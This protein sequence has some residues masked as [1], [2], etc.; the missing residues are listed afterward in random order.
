MS[1]IPN[2]QAETTAFVTTAL[3]ASGATFDSGIL[4][5]AN[6]SQVQTEIVASH[7]GTIDISFCSDA[8]G[9][10]VVRSLSIPYT[11]ADGYQFFAAPAFVNF[12][13]YEFTNAVGATQTDFYYTT[14]F[15]STAL[16]PQLLTTGAFIAPAMVAHLSR[17]I[18]VGKNDAGQFKNVNVDNQN[19][20]KVNASNPKTSYDE[21][22]T[23][24]LSPIAQLT[25]AY[26]VNTDMNILTL[27]NGGT[28]T[29]ADNMAIIQSNTT[30]NGS[31][32]LQ[33]K[34][35]I[36]F[37]SGQGCLSRFDA[38]FT[39]GI[40]QAGS[41]QWIG[42]GDAND[43]FMFGYDT[44]NFSLTYRT[45]GSAVVINQADWNI[46][47]MDGTAGSSNPS[48]VLLDPT[49][50]NVY[51]ISYGSG[52]GN[53]NYSI[54]SDS[55]GDMVLVHILKYGNL[56]TVPAA[57]N[58][59]FPMCAES[60]NGGA[61]TNLI[62]KVAMMSSFI[63]GENAITGPINA[64]ENSKSIGGTETSVFS[65]QNKTTFASKTNKVNVI[66]ETVSLVNDTNAPG[67]FRLW[68]DATLGGTPSYTDISTNTSV[69]SVDTAGT[70]IT[71]GK[72]LWA[73]AVGKDNGDTINLSS[74]RIKL[75][76]GS[77]YTFSAQGGGSATMAVAIVWREDF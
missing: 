75:R 27:A 73:G 13:K 30:A 6:Y 52:F 32:V 40:A 76:P 77:T 7:D 46:D 51:Q 33:S 29:Q 34:E 31:A 24:H 14:K 44:T 20:L 3:L 16:S 63:E 69:I 21:L 12:I 47:K 10:D 42:V 50:G 25:Y 71:G 23:S 41:R 49:K 4:D 38:V 9:L 54:E 68:E 66:L 36:T 19:H 11:A 2:Q 45:N 39:T 5:A 17:N 62:V 57:Y 26:N 28:I 35:T 55:T 65:L 15:L 58:P 64:Y 61:T 53:V 72:L 37:R 60:D 67:T 70:T 8:A 48:G 74:L 18:I 56:N 59:T 22:P 43:G 1:Y